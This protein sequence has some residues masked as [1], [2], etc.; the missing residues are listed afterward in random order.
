MTAVIF[1]DSLVKHEWEK[2]MQND[3][4]EADETIYEV[5]IKLRSRGLVNE[6]NLSVEVLPD[7]TEERFRNVPSIPGQ[8]PSVLMAANS[9]L[10]F[11]EAGL[12]NPGEE[13]V[14]EVTKVVTN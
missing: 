4:A 13:N 14:A 10:E 3:N 1:Y 6:L 8:V 2:A 7:G 5:V 12:V 9:I 11:I